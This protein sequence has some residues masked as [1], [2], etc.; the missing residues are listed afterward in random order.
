[1]KSIDGNGFAEKI[2]GSLDNLNSLL[3]KKELD[4]ALQRFER[5][6]NSLERTSIRLE[7]VVTQNNV[8]KMNQ[9]L[10]NLDRSTRNL[11]QVTTN[12]Q[13]TELFNNLN[14]FLIAGK[15]I[16][17]KTEKNSG[18]VHSEFKNFMDN[19]ENS[20]IRLENNL[21]GISHLLQD[22]SKDPGQ[23]IHGKREPQ[24]Q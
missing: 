5:I 8:D 18:A 21:S 20:I 23:V 13:M 4:A 11:L 10:T 7:K 9:A 15:K 17:D 12:R 3:N 22:F 2:N 6:G 16:I 19:L 14:V 1:M 24:V